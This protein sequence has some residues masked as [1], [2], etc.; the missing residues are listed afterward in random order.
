MFEFFTQGRNKEMQSLFD[1]VTADLEKVNLSKFAINKA[2]GMIA[3]AIAR[4]EIVLVDKNGKRQDKYYF[5]LN[6]RPNDN[7]TGTDFWR[8]VVEKMLLE[9]ECLIVRIGEKYYIANS[10][11]ESDNVMTG[12][13]YTNVN[14][15]CA[16]KQFSLR[17]SFLEDD[18][19]RLRYDNADITR[20][21]KS[22]VEQYDKTLDAIN[23]MIRIANKPRFLL[24]MDTSIKLVEQS[25][26]EGKP[27]KMVTK[28]QYAEKLKGILESD[29]LSILTLAK[30]IDF[31]QFKIE[32]NAKSEDLTKISKEV[33]SAC[34]MAFDIPEAVF[35][36]NITEKSD[37]TNELITYAVSPIVEIINDSLNAK[38][39]GEK[40]F[41]NGEKIFIWVSR[42]KHVDVI[43]S[44][45]SLD[46]LR[47]IGFNYDEIREMVG[48]QALNTNFSTQRALTKN[49]AS[50]EEV[51]KDETSQDD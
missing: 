19:M 29:D 1:I 43:D 36:G 7:E 50:A 30:G 25:K 2:V 17:R 8:N 37:A 41:V 15:V 13:V 42:F 45:A 12:R 34:A 33:L 9:S 26:E 14:I 49:Y 22:V 44:A 5:K 11:S 28:D 27:D 10:Y 51:N 3:N 32:C 23:Q 47:G 35:F 46:K 18:V 31:S 48:Y 39:V 24:K 16:G 38:L 21:L 4:S 6:V 20:H 40:S